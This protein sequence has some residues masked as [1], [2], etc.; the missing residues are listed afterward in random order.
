MEFHYPGMTG[1]QFDE[2]ILFDESRLKFIVTGEVA[3]VEHFDRVLVFGDSMG[4]LHH[5]QIPPIE[6]CRVGGKARYVQWNRILPLR[7]RQS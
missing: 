6:S 5:L 4:G 3:L 7:C 1:S 2:G